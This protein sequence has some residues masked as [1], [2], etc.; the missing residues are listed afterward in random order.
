MTGLSSGK[1][2]QRSCAPLVYFLPQ[3]VQASLVSSKIKGTPFSF[4]LLDI[5]A[6]YAYA[7]SYT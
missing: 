2:W 4:D 3:M 7:H 6:V 5:A 1:R